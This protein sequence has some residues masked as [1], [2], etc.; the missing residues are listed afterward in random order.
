MYRGL[1]RVR[2]MAAA[3]V[4][5]I[6]QA[7]AAWSAPLEAYG[8][9]PTLE[10]VVISP[11]GERLAFV[12]SLN[13]ERTIALADLKGGKSGGLLRAGRQKVRDLQWAGPSHLLITTSTKTFIPGLI[14][15]DQEYFGVQTYN[16]E[17]R[18]TI[19]FLES[20]TK[21]A[22]ALN[23]VTSTPTLRTVD[24]KIVA[25]VRGVHFVGGRGVPGLFK[26][27]VAT[28]RT[29][30]VEPGGRGSY[31]WVVS[32]EGRPLARA[33]YD[34]GRRRWMLK[35]N[36]KGWTERLGVDA[37]IER[38]SLVGLSPDGT[39]VLL[40]Q[41]KDDRWQITSVTPA[42]ETNEGGLSK[43]VFQG[44]IEDPVTHRVIG[45]VRMGV[46]YEYEFFNKRDQAAWD[47]VVKAFPGETVKLESWSDN[48]RRIVVRVDG[49]KN[50]AAFALVDLDA[51]KADWI[52]DLYSG[53]TPADI[54]PVER[55]AY[56]AADGLDIPAY[57]TLPR[58]RPA[59]SLPL[60][61]LPHGGPAARDAPN[62][63]W[64]SQALAAQGYAVLQ[65]QFRGSDGF[66]QRFLAAGFGEWG[67]KM[68]SDLEDG[69]RKL[70]QDGVVDPK[71]VCI[72]G[73]S[74]GG[75]AA[76]AGAAFDG[77]L[78]RCAASVAG[79]SDLRRFL[80]WRA[81]R[82]GGDRDTPQMRYWTRFMG[83]DNPRDTKLQAISPA[84][85][86]DRVKIPVLLIHGQDDTVVGFEQSRIMAE[87]LKK[88][89]KPVSLVALKGED[90]WLSR[91]ETRLQML[92]SVVDFLKANNPPG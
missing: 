24:N 83:A 3:V 65:P 20:G 44:A 35:F 72:V 46:A 81:N 79:L 57:L 75:Y 7:P 63:D 13:E 60:V 91:E 59:K 8:R 1:K 51:H 73:A 82:Q 2:C 9:L 42:G 67:R 29:T 22:M 56:K 15:P 50:G 45:G 92:R 54:S 38:P 58:D 69:V 85:F 86:V 14:G 40:A 68:Q 66:G 70:V 80:S 43:S 41:L 74:Y 26:V 36:D 10:N 62:F 78:Y 55:I 6:V 71:R 18:K 32:A 4:M 90:H 19:G 27:D 53:L 34:D 52:G 48:R 31:D 30:L 23:I 25:F 12:T 61:V 28:G 33:D 89:G 17:T 77:D 21:D 88:A 87:A 37:P 5:F 47:A 11:N 49:P 84:E 16:V 76:L 39:G 64:W